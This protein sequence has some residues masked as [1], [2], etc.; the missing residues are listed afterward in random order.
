MA[1]TLDFISAIQPEQVN[2]SEDRQVVVYKGSPYE[3]QFPR[4]PISRQTWAPAALTLD[5]TQ[6]INLCQFPVRTE[7]CL[8]QGN[9]L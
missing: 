9:K 7:Y 2:G 4:R 5:T 3:M 6:I 8:S 1:K